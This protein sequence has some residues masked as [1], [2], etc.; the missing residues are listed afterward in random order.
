MTRS[1]FSLD[2]YKGY[3]YTMKMTLPL[4]FEW[5]DAKA[6]GNE[7]KHGVPFDYAALV[8]LDPD[9][10]DFDGSRPE[11]DEVRRK[12]VGVIEGRSFTVVYTMRGVV[13]RLISA[14]RAIDQEN[15]RYG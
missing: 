8:F 2:I 9:R 3:T 7:A 11:E 13:I 14:R 15:R 4:T 12:V 6:A 10:I 5:D 1:C